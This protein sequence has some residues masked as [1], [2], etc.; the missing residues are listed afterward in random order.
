MLRALSEQTEL[1]H[2]ACSGTAA[3]K[4][5]AASASAR[6]A[7]SARL[8]AGAL[9]CPGTWRAARLLPT[10]APGRCSRPLFCP[11]R[12]AVAAAALGRCS[13]SSV[14]AWHAPVLA[15]RQPNE[16]HS[17]QNASLLRGTLI[18]TRIAAHTLH[19]L[20]CYASAARSRR[21]PVL[22]ILPV[23][24]QKGFTS[25]PARPSRHECPGQKAAGTPSDILHTCALRVQIKCL[26]GSIHRILGS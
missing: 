6:H 19:P 18:C 14:S 20:C 1:L 8:P 25:C 2:F 7:C 22:S 15:V 17:A 11:I 9:A 3:T 21:C 16:Q 4:A 26:C 13:G 12:A 24:L 23:L 5:G 10:G